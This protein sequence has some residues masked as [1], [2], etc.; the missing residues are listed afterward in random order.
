MRSTFIVCSLSTVIDQAY[1]ALENLIGQ[2]D[3]KQ[4][5]GAGVEIGRLT[6]LG[7][8][9]ARLSQIAR[10][11]VIE[12]EWVARHSPNEAESGDKS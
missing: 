9:I 5:I 11:A 7:E 12:D 2:L 1:K 10:E 4:W 6:Q 3:S 8:Q